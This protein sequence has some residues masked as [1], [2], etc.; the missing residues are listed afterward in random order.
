[1]WI[2][3][4]LGV[5]ALLAATM[6]SIGPARPAP[7]DPSIPLNAPVIDLTR[8]LRPY[9]QSSVAETAE[10]ESWLAFDLSNPGGREMSRIVTFDNGGNGALRFLYGDDRTAWLD[11]T[12]TSEGGRAALRGNRHAV[13]EVSIAPGQTATF[14]LRVRAPNSSSIWRLWQPEAFAA[15]QRLDVL[16]RGLLAGC[17]L[18]MAAWLAGLAVAR[19]SGA[20]GWAAIA[21]GA[22]VVLLLGDSVIA[23]PTSVVAGAGGVFLAAGLRFLSS[24]LEISRQRPWLAYLLDGCIFA[25]LLLCFV[26]AF[27]IAPAWLLMRAATVLAAAVIGA[28]FFGRLVE[29]DDSARALIPG[30]LLL[31]LGCLAPNFLPDQVARHVTTLPL[32]VDALLTAGALA[33]GFAGSSQRQTR[34]GEEV[35]AELSEE[36]RQAREVEYR[37]A[38]GLAA[39]HQGLWDWNLENDT[40]FLSP[41]V[42]ALLGLPNSVI[43]SSERNWAALILPEDVGVYADAINTHRKLGNSSFTV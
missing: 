1:M 6:L 19:A 10:L 7:A 39:A 37:Y 26:A 35:S 40:L 36:R 15:H 13:G 42:E 43:G 41:S 24:Y 38:L 25:I 17:V 16:M 18:A 27:G 32:I 28:S 33:L 4:G 22:S 9:D 14:A 30:V 23:L 5:I 21:L 2:R 34:S 8:S 20:Q 3:G 29:G 31:G 11:L 12:A